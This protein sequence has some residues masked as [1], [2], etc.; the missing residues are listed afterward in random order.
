LSAAKRTEEKET[1]M[2]RITAVAF[3]TL[4]SILGAGKTLA[5]SH[6]VRAAVP[7]DFTVGDKLLPEGSYSIT[8]VM[9]GAIEIWN[10]GTHIGVLTQ[11]SADSNR[12]QNGSE[13]VFEKAAGHYFL[14]EILCESAAMNVNLPTTKREKRARVEEA[15]MHND[16]GQ[17][18]IAIK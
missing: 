2:K 17:V 4:A 12:S 14:R 9:D 15:R 11:A 3:F 18:L 10:R 5:Q 13:L 7:F 8:P 1:I 6:E 16:G